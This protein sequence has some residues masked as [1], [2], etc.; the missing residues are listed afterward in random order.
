[1]EEAPEKPDDPPEQTNSVSRKK[2][3]IVSAEKTENVEKALEKLDDQPM[4]TKKAIKSKKKSPI[5]ILIS[6]LLH[7]DL[8]DL[9]IKIDNQ[10]ALVN[11]K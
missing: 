6:M 10:Q 4:E 7:T 9:V 5:V 11:I 1:V 2:R 3:W 8:I